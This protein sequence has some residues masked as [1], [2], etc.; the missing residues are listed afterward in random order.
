[1]LTFEFGARYTRKLAG[2]IAISGHLHNPSCLLQEMNL[3]IKDAN[4][5]C[6]HG[7]EDEALEFNTASQQIQL[8]Q[9]GGM[10]IK[11]L[12]YQKAHTIEREEIEM[13]QSWI[14]AIV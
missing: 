6:T 11:F 10:P 7:T 13:I 9:Q 12:P 3:Q 8:L 14:S 4:W 2:C 5:L 1:M